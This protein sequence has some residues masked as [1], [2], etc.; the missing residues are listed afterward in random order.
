MEPL[1]FSTHTQ[2]ELKICHI[3]KHATQNT[4]SVKITMAVGWNYAGC[5]IYQVFGRQATHR[6]GP[7]RK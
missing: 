2:S 3:V 4:Q 6:R 7:H 1:K 5:V